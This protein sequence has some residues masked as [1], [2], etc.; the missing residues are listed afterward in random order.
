MGS[1]IG[2]TD[3]AT[4]I[5]LC[6]QVDRLGMD[7]NESGYVIAHAAVRPALLAR[8]A[9]TA[10]VIAVLIFGVR[11]NRLLDLTRDTG[12]SLVLPNAAALGTTPSDR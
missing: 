4:T 9:L 11:P 6:N 12:R 2:Q 3:P 10:T 1:L 5:Y 7:I 8:I